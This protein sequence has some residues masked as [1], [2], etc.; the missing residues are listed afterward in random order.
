MLTNVIH[1]NYSDW[2]TVD[3]CPQMCNHSIVEHVDT[4]IIDMIILPVALNYDLVKFSNVLRLRG[5]TW[6]LAS[7]N[8]IHWLDAVKEWINFVNSFV[9]GSEA[10][11]LRSQIVPINMFIMT[12]LQLTVDLDGAHVRKAMRQLWKWV[13][14]LQSKDT[15]PYFCDTEQ[16][17]I[18][19][20]RL[21]ADGATIDCGPS[22]RAWIGGRARDDVKT[23]ARW[24]TLENEYFG[25]G[26]SLLNHACVAHANAFIEYDHED[27][28]VSLEQIW[29]DVSIRIVYDDCQSLY[30][31]R[32]ISCNVCATATCENLHPEE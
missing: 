27:E 2:R 3:K 7:R 8:I 14:F 29:P 9:K 28:V 31:S 26:P 20:T 22:L 21:I 18:L 24:S 4:W 11:W 6:V 15:R 5:S 16:L 19:S 12:A 30:N 23:G 1:C 32:H 17:G 13:L 25:G 10:A